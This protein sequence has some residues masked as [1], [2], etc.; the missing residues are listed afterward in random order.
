MLKFVPVMVTAV[1]TVPTVGLKLV[2]VGATDDPTVNGEALVAVPL[3]AVTAIDPV[4]AP[5]GTV[6]V[7]CVVVALVTVAD[8]LFLNFTVF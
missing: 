5:A 1:P 2:I 6:T 7:S 8:L 3:G 4:V